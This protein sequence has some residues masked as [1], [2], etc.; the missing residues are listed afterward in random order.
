MQPNAPLEPKAP[1][2]DMLEWLRGGSRTGGFNCIVAYDRAKTNTVLLQEYIKHF[3]DGS[4]MDPINMEVPTSGKTRELTYDYI[5]DAGRLSFENA[6]IAESKARLTMH[7]IG[8]SQVSLEESD[9]GQ[10]RVAG[11]S[12]IDALQGPLVYMDIKLKATEGYIDKEGKAYL[13]L[14]DT[15]EVIMLTFAATE[16]ERKIGGEFLNEY[17]QGLPEEQQIHVLNDLVVVPGQYL[18]PQEFF[19]RTH[20]APGGKDPNSANLGSGAVL[21]F[22]TTEGQ[23]NGSIVVKDEDQPYLIPDGHSASMLLGHDFLMSK[24]FSEGCRAMADEGSEY[25][26]QLVTNDEGYITHMNVLRGIASSSD[27]T[28]SSAF[29]KEI[30][31][32]LIAFPLANGDVTMTCKFTGG[33]IQLEWKGIWK[34]RLKVV[35]MNDLLQD[36]DADTFWHMTRSF[37]PQLDSKTG[38]VSLV[39]LDETPLK[40]LKISPGD[41]SNGNVIPNFKEIT[42]FLEPRLTQRLFDTLAKFSEPASAIDVFRLNSILFRGDNVVTLKD[43]FQPRDMFLIGDISPTLTHFALTPMDEKVGPEG[44]VSF[45]TVPE[46]SGVTWSVAKVPGSSDKIGSISSSGV[47]TP[48]KATELDGSFTRVMVTAK[49]GSYQQ[50]ALVSI[51][52]RDI[53]LN[54]LVVSMG[55]SSTVPREMAAGTLGDGELEWS[56]ADP[57][58][59]SKILPSTVEFG[60]KAFHPG[61]AQPV[62]I[63]VEEVRVRN[64]KTGSTVSSFVV[65]IHVQGSLVIRYEAT[66]KPDEVQLIFKHEIDEFPADENMTLT[67]VAGSGTINADGLFKI[68]PV[69]KYPFAVVEALYNNGPFKL[70]GHIILPIPFLDLPK[71]LEVQAKCLAHQP[72]QA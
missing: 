66:D 56:L 50:S 31:A 24:I 42:D 46:I 32:R 16:R 67:V 44:K 47:Y 23:K 60:D 48:P 35:T 45:K 65:V 9:S 10:L 41:H 64:K 36:F 71:A 21:V 4:Y 22:I 49:A 19:I 30:T 15:F 2:E 12:S 59:G 55:V 11:I 43:V 29:F 62:H 20:A 7:V 37:E 13:D 8:G 63:I 6:T 68:D 14:N 69:G 34:F 70:R 27:I 53:A 28:G 18:V 3:T 52:T 1:L 17:F 61:P 72:G 57:S 58:T 54:P 51:V 38:T 40:L 5:L 39:A 33:R 25:D 26:F